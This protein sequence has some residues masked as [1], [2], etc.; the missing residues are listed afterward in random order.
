MDETES[1]DQTS[2]QGNRPPLSGALAAAIE[3]LRDEAIRRRANLSATPRVADIIRRIVRQA[4]AEGLRAEQ[5]VIAFHT[6]WND[7][8]RPLS[9]RLS[10]RDD[11]LVG[12][13]I[14]A[15]YGRGVT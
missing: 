13:L 10:I 14:A 11:R 8:T 7:L 6:V 15:F 12:A 3:E 2:R 1:N 4:H 5:L 9:S